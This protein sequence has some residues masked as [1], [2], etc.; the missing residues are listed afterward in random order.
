MKTE[1]RIKVDTNGACSGTLYVVRDDKARI[2]C[3]SKDETP[4][5]LSFISE[6]AAELRFAL[7]DAVDARSAAAAIRKVSRQDAVITIL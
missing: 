6:N 1:F 4:H 7:Q 2:Q 5:S 3:Y